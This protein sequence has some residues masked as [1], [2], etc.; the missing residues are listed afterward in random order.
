MDSWN[1]LGIQPC[2]K[3]VWKC[4]YSAKSNKGLVSFPGRW[5]LVDLWGETKQF[6]KIP[7]T[8]GTWLIEFLF[9]RYLWDLGL[10]P[11]LGLIVCVIDTVV[12]V[13]WSRGQSV[14]HL[15][16]CSDSVVGANLKCT[17]MLMAN[18]KSIGIWQKRS[19]VLACSSPWPC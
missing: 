9:S 15:Y 10:S 17:S 12:N 14:I 11:D 7:Q 18:V 4:I 5:A 13:W 6:I 16:C 2:V 8:E 19:H 3:P 1:T